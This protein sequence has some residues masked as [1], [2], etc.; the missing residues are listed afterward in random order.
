MIDINLGIRNNYDII[1]IDKKEGIRIMNKESFKPLISENDKKEILNLLNEYKIDLKNLHIDIEDDKYI[2]GIFGEK[3]KDDIKNFFKYNH[4][5]ESI[6]D[7]STKT[8]LSIVKCI[9]EYQKV[10]YYLFNL[11]NNN[12]SESENIACYYFENALFREIILWDSLA[13]LL[14]LYYNLGKDVKKVSYKNILKELSD[15]N[16]PELDFSEILSYISEKFDISDLDINKGVH[17]YICDLRNQM[18]HRYSIA[19]TSLSENTFL[20]IMPDSVYRIAKDYNTVQKYLIQVINL[21]TVSI[22]DN[23]IVERI[24]ST[25]IS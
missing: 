23:K 25:D 12:L 1:M 7:L 17:D 15:K 13:Q 5:I 2:V 20:R 9:E 8:K 10:N 22:N 18:T 21:I 24:I 19:I 3:V 16:Y 11:M 4:F 6:N 14:N